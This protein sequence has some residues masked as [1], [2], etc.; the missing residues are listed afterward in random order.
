M[1][2]EQSDIHFLL[3]H[4]MNSSFQSSFL[5]HVSKSNLQRLH[6]MLTDRFE[7]QELTISDTKAAWKEWFDLAAYGGMLVSSDLQFTTDNTCQ[8][9]EL[10]VIDL[11]IE[12]ACKHIDSL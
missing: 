5:A 1:K 8:H 7:E 12:L 6:E 4:Y 3:A 2:F 11:V 10:R 9:D